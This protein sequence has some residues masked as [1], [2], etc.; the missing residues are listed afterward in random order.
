MRDNT[1]TLTDRQKKPRKNA[2]EL[3]DGVMKRGNTSNVGT[4]VAF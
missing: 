2:P 4:E 3:R 1:A